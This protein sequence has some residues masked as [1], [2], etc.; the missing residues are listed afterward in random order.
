MT[1]ETPDLAGRAVATVRKLLE[2]EWF[3][4]AR[5]VLDDACVLHPNHLELILLN[6][7]TYARQSQMI[8]ALQVLVDAHRRVP[9]HADLKLRLGQFLAIDG[10]HVAMD[11]FDRTE[12]QHE[13]PAL[14]ILERA[15]TLS[16][17][18]RF[19]D[20][21]K[22]VERALEIEPGYWDAWMEMGR[23]NIELGDWSAAVRPLRRAMELEG[24]TA[25]LA[26]DL[27]AAYLHQGFVDEAEKVLDQGERLEPAHP[28][29][30]YYRAA[31]AAG[32]GETGDA[33]K[34]LQKALDSG[35]EGIRRLLQADRFFD[36]LRDRPELAELSGTPRTEGTLRRFEPRVDRKGPRS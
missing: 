1:D 33:L 7:E 23:L 18:G 31:V 25:E 34:Y 8:E 20:A 16:D 9:E 11:L 28:G 15:M 17:L 4:E 30:A 12:A 26:V 24:P 10:L 27:A 14:V 19:R 32:R 3:D 35:H 21:L 2:R 13:F 36:A 5:R 29:F 6:A 22:E